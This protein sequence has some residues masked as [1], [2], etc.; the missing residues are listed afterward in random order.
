MLILGFAQEKFVLVSENSPFYINETGDVV[1]RSL[2]ASYTF[3]EVFKNKEQLITCL[4][5]IAS[6]CSENKIGFLLTTQD[7]VYLSSNMRFYIDKVD[8]IILKEILK[9]LP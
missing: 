3:S 7:M 4:Q 6:Y 1:S 2:M 8:P 5:A 9:E